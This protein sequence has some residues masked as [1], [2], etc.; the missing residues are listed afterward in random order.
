M[1]TLDFIDI[2]QVRDRLSAFSRRID[3]RHKL[4]FVGI[5]QTLETGL[6]KLSETAAGHH[7]P[8]T[9]IPLVVTTAWN[10]KL[11]ITSRYIRLPFHGTD[12]NKPLIDS[13]TTLLTAY[14]NP[15]EHFG[16]MDLT[17]QHNR[18]RQTEVIER[19][20]A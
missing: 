14:A 3:P 13:Y 10:S 11:D 15:V 9:E 19:L 2:P 12:G 16:D 7:S 8:D 5:F 17:T 6:A 4:L 20:L 18:L 1:A